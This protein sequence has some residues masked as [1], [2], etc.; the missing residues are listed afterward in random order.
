MNSENEKKILINLVVNT[1]T[2]KDRFNKIKI[3][4]RNVFKKCKC[5]RANSYGFLFK[6]ISGLR[7]NS[8][9]GVQALLFT[10]K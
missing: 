9:S 4:E 7:M 3:F 2:Q 6:Y 10:Y 5:I 8:C 1:N